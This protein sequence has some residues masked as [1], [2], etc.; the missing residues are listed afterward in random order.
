MRLDVVIHVETI[1]RLVRDS[2]TKVSDKIICFSIVIL[3][4][5]PFGRWNNARPPA[6]IVRLWLGGLN[7]KLTK[8]S[9]L[10]LTARLDLVGTWRNVGRGTLVVFDLQNMK[11]WWYN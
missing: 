11:V 10:S 7:P 6:V 5:R 1:L 2:S 3:A 4:I 8:T 9:I